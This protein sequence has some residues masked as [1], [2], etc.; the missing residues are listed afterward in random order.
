MMQLFFLDN[1]QYV[2]MFGIP[3]GS[4]NETE[5]V[6]WNTSN[7]IFTRFPTFSIVTNKRTIQTVKSNHDKGPSFT[8]I[9]MSKHPCEESMALDFSLG[10]VAGS[11]FLL[12]LCLIILILRCKK[13]Y[14]KHNVKCF[15]SLF[16]AHIL[17]AVS[18][19]LSNLYD[20]VEIPLL[21]NA[22][23]LQMFSS[24]MIASIDRFLAIKYPFRYNKITTRHV[25]GTVA[26]S[27]ILSMVFFASIVVIN[28]QQTSLTILSSCLIV[29]S[30][31]V[32]TATNFSVY[33]LAKRHSKA[34]E[35]TTVQTTE[36]RNPSQRNK[37]IYVCFALVASFVVLWLPYLTY[38]ILKLLGFND[39]CKIL[40]RSTEFFAFSNSVLD[41]VLFVL[42]R[43][44]VKT[45]FVSIWRTKTGSHGA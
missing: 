13:L 32:L 41:P 8:N 9:E 2:S 23:L 11:M 15:I 26:I 20:N 10:V 33:S 27:W 7:N 25:N 34:I 29:V 30:S 38:N 43:K 17:M 45:C 35:K 44:D 39:Q 1:I 37:F 12:N 6:V 19:F 22:L 5:P 40:L 16:T 24:L 21:M 28:I 31:L 18:Q 3:S 4:I 14:R 36:N 42:F